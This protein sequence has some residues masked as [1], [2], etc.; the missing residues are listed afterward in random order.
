MC[1]R[2]PRPPPWA[3]TLTSIPHG[4]GNRYVCLPTHSL[5]ALQLPI[6]NNS[7]Q[8]NIKVVVNTA[9]IV[10]YNTTDRYV[11]LQTHSLMALQLRTVSN[12]TSNVV[13]NSISNVANN[14]I[15]RCGVFEH[16]H[17]WRSNCLQSTT[18]VNSASKLSSTPQAMWQ[19]VQPTDT[20][21]FKHIL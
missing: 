11:C 10:A 5:L 18:V 12:S 4:P 2:H 7:S 14:T 17:Y 13:H 6:V 21:V 20:C 16:I 8:Q 1:K 3:Y 9:S 15:D 19:T